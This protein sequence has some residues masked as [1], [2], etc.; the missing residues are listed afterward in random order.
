M[1]H[2]LLPTLS[3][4]KPESL[5]GIKPIAGEVHGYAQRGEFDTMFFFPL[6]TGRY[7]AEDVLNPE[8]TGTVVVFLP[9]DAVVAG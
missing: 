6:Q 1:L 2:H 5:H 7:E 9:D 8:I 3:L 4:T